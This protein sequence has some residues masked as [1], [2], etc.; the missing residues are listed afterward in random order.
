MHLSNGAQL[1]STCQTQSLLVLR[2]SNS[3]GRKAHDVVGCIAA[4]FYV[5]RLRHLLRLLV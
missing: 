4:V 2:P 3:C 1:P 5:L